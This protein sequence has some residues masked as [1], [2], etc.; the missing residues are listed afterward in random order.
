MEKEFGSLAENIVVGIG[1]SIGPCCYKVGPDIISQFENTFHTTKG[2]IVNKSDD[3]TGYLDLW[4]ANLDQLIHAG[5]ERSNIELARI[6]TQDN[7]ALFFSYRHQQ[8][9]TGRFGAG[10]TLVSS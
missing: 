2:L 4:K 1:P 5:I 3:G 9:D 7:S 10:I 6:C 8:G